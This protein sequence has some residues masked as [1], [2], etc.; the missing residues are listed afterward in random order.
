MFVLLKSTLNFQF[1]VFFVLKFSDAI[2]DF[3]FPFFVMNS[4]VMIER[5]SFNIKHT[6]ISIYK[7]NSESFPG[8]FEGKLFLFRN[9]ICSNEEWIFC[10]RLSIFVRI[11]FKLLIFHVKLQ[12]MVSNENS[13]SRNIN[14][15]SCCCTVWAQ[16]SVPC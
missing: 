6:N 1:C 4:R 12:C 2:H 15:C 9:L 10:S 7:G 13:F 14:K 5:S 16:K 11:N 3:S 8:K